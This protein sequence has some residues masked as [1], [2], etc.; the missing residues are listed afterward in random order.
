MQ[1]ETISVGNLQQI[2]DRIA[3]A[4]P[5]PDDPVVE[6]QDL[7]VTD[8]ASANRAGTLVQALH[9]LA[10]EVKA[11]HKPAVSGAHQLHKAVKAKMDERLK[12]IAETD[13][14]LRERVLRWYRDELERRKPASN[15]NGHDPEAE[16]RIAE[17]VASGVAEES[18][19]ALVESQ[20]MLA[21][22]SQPEG[23]E[24]AG[25][26]FAE[27]WVGEVT[28]LEAVLWGILDGALPMG[29][30]EVNSKVLNDLARSHANSRKFPGLAFRARI[31]VRRKA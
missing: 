13:E 25:L 30:I 14:L 18:A 6:A 16:S 4:P 29:L 22:P 21:A 8:Q 23:V 10:E 2:I 17:Y 20:R 3:S 24:V 1:Q 15:G 5:A 28:D 12:P 19:R 27:Q 7:A 11:E 9:G 26:S 31:Q